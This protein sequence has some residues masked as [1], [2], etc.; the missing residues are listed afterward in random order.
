VVL[1]S[2]KA[3]GTAWNRSPK[4]GS[5]SSRRTSPTCARSSVPVKLPLGLP[6]VTGSGACSGLSLRPAWP[7]ALRRSVEIAGLDKLTDP[8]R[9]KVTDAVL[10]AV[11]KESNGNPEREIRFEWVEHLLKTQR[12]VESGTFESDVREEL[13]KLINS[14]SPDNPPKIEE[15]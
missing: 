3:A 6:L 5:R 8:D 9:R 14:S 7:G 12:D 10:R 13:I 15:L 2:L 4:L 1:P 11:E